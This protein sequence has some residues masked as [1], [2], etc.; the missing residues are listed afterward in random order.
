MKLWAH[1]WTRASK[2]GSKW[3]TKIFCVVLCGI[4]CP[5][6][7]HQFRPAILNMS[8]QILPP[9]SQAPRCASS[10]SAWMQHALSAITKMLN[11]TVLA[12]WHCT[13]W[14]TKMSYCFSHR[15]NLQC[16][17]DIDR[18]WLSWYYPCCI[19]TEWMTSTLN[20]EEW[21]RLIECK[22]DWLD[23]FWC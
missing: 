19:F 10:I 8:P 9:P 18:L 16:Y 14:Q 7:L 3:W 12:F 13:F 5:V 1:W 2:Y 4:R 11:E 6:N 15:F 22:L 23:T 21:N 17:T 20:C